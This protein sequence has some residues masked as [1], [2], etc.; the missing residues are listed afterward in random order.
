MQPYEGRKPLGKWMVK[1]SRFRTDAQLYRP[2]RLSQ[3][4][5]QSLLDHEAPIFALE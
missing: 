5:Q 4:D 1:Y 3:Q 2:Y